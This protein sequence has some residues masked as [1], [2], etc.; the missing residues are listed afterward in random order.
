MV[1]I[2]CGPVGILTQM[3]AQLYGPARVL[4][5]DMVESRLQMAKSIGSIPINAK[6]GDVGPRIKEMPI[7]AV[8]MR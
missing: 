6:E 1:V 5:V 7:F 8:R 4:A 3:C 2:G